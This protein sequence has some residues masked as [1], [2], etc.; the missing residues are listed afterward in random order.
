[1]PSDDTETML[2]I[3]NS[4]LSQIEK[5]NS[6]V[7]KDQ[8]KGL[9]IIKNIIKNKKLILHGGLAVNAVLP[10]DKQFYDELTVPDYD[11][12]IPDDTGKET[13]KI[14][15]EAQ[16]KLSDAE[17]W[18]HFQPAIHGNT[19]KLRSHP[20][21]ITRLAALRYPNIFD[22]TSIP[23]KDFEKLKVLSETEKKLRSAEFRSFL[24]VPTAYMKMSMHL[25]FSRPSVHIRRWSKLFPRTARL[26][27]TYPTV[28]VGKLSSYKPVSYNYDP[29]NIL[30]K[31][32]PEETF[33]VGEFVALKIMGKPD[34]GRLDAVTKD[35]S[36]A[37]DLMYDSGLKPSDIVPESTFLPEH[38]TV[39]DCTVYNW[40]ECSAV[41][42]DGL[43]GN[44]DTLLR[45]FYGEYLQYERTS[46]ID[47]L[48]EFQKNQTARDI[49]GGLGTRFGITCK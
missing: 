3:E 49:S 46:I 37:H 47:D 36:K 4:I 14:M 12:M 23:K 41:V 33:L 28:I 7:M 39:G 34:G 38:F 25:E 27:E 29:I 22:A 11:A 17:Y 19:Q 18:A 13:K 21:G 30:I 32:Y 40:E 26:Y 1:M 35:L 31:T 5:D 15:F 6:H 42:N 44:S 10:K 45:Y 8:T 48:V 9:N 24:L 43:F 16:R 20:K 2:V